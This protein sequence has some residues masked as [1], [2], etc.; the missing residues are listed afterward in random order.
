LKTSMVFREIQKAENITAPEKEV[1]TNI[2]YLKLQYK[3]RSEAWLRESAEA[4]IIQE[5]IF[6]LL[7]LALQDEPTASTANTI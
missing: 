6:A 1:Q 3:D 7:G 2:A 4:L 5:K